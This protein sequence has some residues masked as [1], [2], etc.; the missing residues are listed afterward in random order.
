MA[1]GCCL[2]TATGFFEV[3]GALSLSCRNAC[4]LLIG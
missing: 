1:L 4:A 2:S 3:L